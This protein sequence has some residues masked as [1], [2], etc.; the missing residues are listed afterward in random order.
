MAAPELFLGKPQALLD[1]LH[2]PLE[3]GQPIFGRQPLGILST[4]HEWL[5]VTPPVA[6]TTTASQLKQK[7][8]CTHDNEG[9]PYSLYPNSIRKQLAT[10]LPG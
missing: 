10:P 8:E 9:Y 7:Q 3:H 1:L 4:G 6:R 2:A 5:D